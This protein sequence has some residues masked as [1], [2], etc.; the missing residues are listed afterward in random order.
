MKTT[1]AGRQRAI[2]CQSG[3]MPAVRSASVASSRAVGTLQQVGDAVAG[4]DERVVGGLDLRPGRQDAGRDQPLPERPPEA[5]LVVVAG[6]DADRRR[7]EPD[8]Q[9]AVAQRRQVGERL[10][11]PAVDRQ[12]RTCEPGPGRP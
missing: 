10:D 9:E 4:G 12:R 7:V 5:S 8:E 6:V 11:G 1:A 2:F 3:P